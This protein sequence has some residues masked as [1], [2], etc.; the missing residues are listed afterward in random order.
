[1]RI[2]KLAL[3]TLVATGAVVSDGAAQ[4]IARDPAI[5]AIDTMLKQVFALNVSPGLGVVVVRDTQIVYMKGFGYAD[6]EAGRPF[7]DSTVFYIG[8][9]TK[10]YTG[11]AIAALD[12]KGAF[13]LDAPLSRYLPDVRLA[14]SLD[15][16]SI[17]I[18]SLIAHTHG[19]GNGGPVVDRLAF[20]GQFNGDAE[21]LRLLEH[22]PAARSG[23]EFSYGNIGYNVATLAMDAQQKRSW[24]ETLQREVF[25]PLGLHNTT[26]YVSKVKA[27]RLAQPYRLTTNG[28]VRRPYGKTDANMQSAGG[29]LTTLPDFG[30]WLEANINDG[31][32]NGRQ[33]LP[34]AVFHEAQ[35]ISA[36]FN[37][38]TRGQTQIGYALGWNV[39]L[40]DGD[41]L[42]A[43]GGG[44]PGFAA[45]IGFMPR[46]KIGV[47]LFA[48]NS[49]LGPV[50]EIAGMEILRILRG[51]QVTAESMASL[52][53]ILSNGRRGFLADQERRAARPQTLPYPL[54]AYTG[55]FDNA[56]LGRLVIR[57]NN[58]KLEAF[59]GAASS[60]IE[61]FDHS[62]NQLRIE[63]FGNGEVMSVE[64]ADGRARSLTFG[65]QTFTR[66][67]GK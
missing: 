35:R 53:T 21:L 16:D 4:G 1:M 2:P 32:L 5:A 37:R 30:A 65:G 7:T 40:V 24:K 36:A 34:A 60:P 39:L 10:A 44:F 50:T 55:T 62:R 9:I 47:A 64:M 46:Q 26:T 45:S 48:N 13:D 25:A 6:I 31:R 58:G 27:E 23:R 33:A 67:A 3:A 19:I 8:S 12:H 56:L 63:I 22:H 28:F 51:G 52:Q 54:A 17:S 18:R 11:L 38:Q 66:V 43:H 29:M 41:T 42:Y 57:E 49:E 14:T 20:T 61:V 59:M 15:P